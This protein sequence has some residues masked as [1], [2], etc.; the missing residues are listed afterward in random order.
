ME[1]LLTNTSKKLML[2][3]KLVLEL[4]YLEH[5]EEEEQELLLKTMSI[6][7]NKLK[8]LK[9]NYLKLLLIRL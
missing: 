1:Q 4:Q 2:A 9:L 5:F 7:M 6:E 3:I 8:S